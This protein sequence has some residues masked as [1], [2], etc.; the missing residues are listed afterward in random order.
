MQ[1]KNLG[2]VA[3]EA[4]VDYRYELFAGMFVQSSECRVC[5]AERVWEKDLPQL[6]GVE[7]GF[8]ALK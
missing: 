7:L 3:V 6:G 8:L 5:H 4:S 1:G 2:G